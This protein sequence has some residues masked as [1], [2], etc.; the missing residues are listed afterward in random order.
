MIEY[1]YQSD[2]DW[3]ALSLLELYDIINLAELFNLPKVT[4]EIKTQMEVMPLTMDSLMEVAHTAAQFMQF[5]EVSSALLLTCSKFLQNTVRTPADQLQ[6]A[7]DQ[8]DTGR[9]KTVL[10]LLSL[11]KSSLLPCTN[12]GEMECLNGKLVRDNEKFTVGMKM[13]VNKKSSEYWGENGGSFASK[14]YTVTEVVDD[15]VRVKDIDGREVYCTALSC[16]RQ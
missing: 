5:Q 15:Q 2:I 1:I 3:S 14:C 4:N 6:F 11:I 9:E 10:E 8:L 16:F 7:L 12:C 13:K